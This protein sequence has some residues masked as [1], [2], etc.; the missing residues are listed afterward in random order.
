M[1]DGQLTLLAPV[2]GVIYPLE[3]V[4]DPVFSQKLVGDGISID[5]TDN[6]LRAPCPGEI[7]QQHAAG[8]AVTL[9]T[10]GG[11]EVL[12]HVGIDT[13]ALKGEGFTPRVKIG[14]KVETGA[15][16]IEFDLD[17]V[18]TNAKSLLT[19]VIISNGERVTNTV[20]GTGTAVRRQDPGVDLD[21]EWRSGGS[22]DRNGP[23]VTSEAIILPNPNGLHAR[24]AAVLS[25]VAKTFKSDV[26]L[27][28]G[29][30]SANARS[31]T[32]LMALET[33]LGDK[34]V[35]VAKGP[36]AREAVDKLTPDDR[37]RTWRRGLRAS[38][39]AGGDECSADLRTGAAEGGD[40]NL[41]VG[42]A[43]SSGLAVGEVFQV[44]HVEIEVEEEGG[45]PDQERR[46][47]DDAIDKAPDSSKPCALSFMATRS[48]RKP[49][50]S[51]RTPSC[52]RTLIC[53]RSPPPLSP[54][55]RARPSP[56][57]APSRPTLTGSP[58]CAT[59]CSRS[60]PTT[61]A[62]WASA[63][64]N[65]SPESNGKLLPTRPTRFSSPK[66]SRRR[67]PPRWSAAR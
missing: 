66:I 49:P 50:S 43:A 37:R 20:Y 55:A 31:V 45:R 51:R 62:T 52:S 58:V 15:A 59:N 8:H 7:V 24:P 61:C 28:L 2:S 48:K 67:T 17:Y 57:K 46:L 40:P 10:A 36:D 33:A 63:C 6:V 56:G 3:R 4:P 23:T 14:D 53:S 16:L 12:M 44:R 9:R 42:V 54:R 38:D 65:S 29:D 1:S 22:G 39:R 32:S 35:F 25:S 5:P 26:R 60:A 13:V 18:A 19:E 41:L 27:Q 30:R 34:V 64:W 47:L 21:L 11:V